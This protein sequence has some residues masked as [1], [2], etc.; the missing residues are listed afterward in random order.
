VSKYDLIQRGEPIAPP[1]EIELLRAEVERER[2][3]AETAIAVL[4]DCLPKQHLAPREY[5]RVNKQ[6]A[7]L[8]GLERNA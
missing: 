3:R 2:A 7:E 4:R 6:R 8:I 1:T 5:L